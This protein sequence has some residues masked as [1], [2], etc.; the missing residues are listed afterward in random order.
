[1]GASHRTFRRFSDFPGVRFSATRHARGVSS[2]SASVSVRAVRSCGRSRARARR[3]DPRAS[4]C[5]ARG[6]DPHQL[7]NPQAKEPSRQQPGPDRCGCSDAAARSE[8]AP[9]APDVRSGPRALA[10]ASRSRIA[11]VLEVGR[12]SALASTR[13]SQRTTASSVRLLVGA[14][15]LPM[16]GAR[17]RRRSR[18]RDGFCFHPGPEAT[19]GVIEH[20]DTAALDA[21]EPRS[22]PRNRWAQG[23]SRTEGATRPTR[24]MRVLARMQK[25]CVL[26]MLRSRMYLG[27]T[28]LQ[29]LPPRRDRAARDA[30]A[31]DLG[32][33]RVARALRPAAVLLRLVAHARSPARG[34][35]IRAVEWW[36]M[37]GRE[38]CRQPVRNL[39]YRARC[40]IRRG[41]RRS[42]DC[43]LRAGRADWAHRRLVCPIDRNRPQ[44]RRSEEV[45][46]PTHFEQFAGISTAMTAGPRVIRVG[47]VPGSNLGA[48]ITEK[49]C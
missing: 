43:G 19:A 6:L 47:E 15:L 31:G 41:R 7:L 29:A 16:H 24:P 20:L 38:R 39:G 11:V 48:P 34:S 23:C 42:G 45:R 13:P 25:P 49:P 5:C 44:I 21:N 8:P 30:G 10:P 3:L 46:R 32:A 28:E 12:L 33:A 27:D 22:R 36:R 35:C 9:R 40:G 18:Y 26:S 14:Q 2:R 1:M 4:R 37:A 17:G